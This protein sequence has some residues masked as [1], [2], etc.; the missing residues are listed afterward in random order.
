M[1]RIESFF[2]YLGEGTNLGSGELGKPNSKTGEARTD[3]L[4]R[5]IQ[6]KIKQQFKKVI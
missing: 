1:L 6:S 3:I 5:L 4:R 2:T